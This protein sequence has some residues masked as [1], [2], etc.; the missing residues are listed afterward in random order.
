[1]SQMIVSYM[2]D[3][4][5][6]LALISSVREKSIERHIQAEENLCKDAHAFGHPNYVSELS[7]C[8]A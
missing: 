2:K 1:M 6:N 8:H 5:S 4:S 3:V 7:T